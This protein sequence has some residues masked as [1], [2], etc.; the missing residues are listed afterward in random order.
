MQNF[1][2]KSDWADLNNGQKTSS[3]AFPGYREKKISGKKSS[4]S[5]A[6]KPLFSSAEKR[7]I[8]IFLSGDETR[9]SSYFENGFFLSFFLPFAQ[10]RVSPESVTVRQPSQ[11]VFYHIT[12]P[13]FT[14][15]AR[16]SCTVEFFFIFLGYRNE[17]GASGGAL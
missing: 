2:K 6:I 9:L 16:S 15:A 3:M 10:R 5:A 17:K 1:G 7:R 12:F 11:D 8:D 14:F 13:H 4:N